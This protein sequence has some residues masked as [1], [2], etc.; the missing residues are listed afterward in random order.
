DDEDA[1][2]LDEHDPPDVVPEVG[3]RRLVRA[4]EQVHAA[5]PDSRTTAPGPAPSCVLISL[6]G[7]RMGSH[8]TRS[9]ISV[10]TTGRVTAPRAP[11]TVSG[12][13]SARSSRAAVSG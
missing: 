6:P 12:S 1:D 2:D 3:Q 7:D 4:G 5:P 11:L 8:T 9:G 13:P 10:T